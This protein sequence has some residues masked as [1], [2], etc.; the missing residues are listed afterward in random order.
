MALNL[1]KKGSTMAGRP[2]KILT[3]DDIQQVYE[4]L[5]DLEFYRVKE[6]K[7]LQMF[8]QF[9]LQNLSEE[10][11]KLV[12]DTQYLM[13]NA[14]KNYELYHQIESKEKHN[15]AERQIIELYQK[16]DI[17]SFF[18]MHDLLHTLRKSN[19]VKIAENKI[20]QRLATSLKE[21]S[22]KKVADHQKYF[23]GDLTLKW[24]H[25]KYSDLSDDQVL[26]AL[27]AM[28]ESERIGSIIRKQWTDKNQNVD[29]MN[30]RIEEIKEIRQ[31]IDIAQSDPRNPF[32]N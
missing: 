26:N 19:N 8:D 23:I 3:S 25:S 17:D 27:K 21:K 11:L 20:K 28:I 15:S 22:P 5:V 4:Y 29:W 24:I 16:E 9:G 1:L 30:S 6:R 14:L 10:Q 12:R 13:N 31:Q 32:K 2:K 18:A 7:C